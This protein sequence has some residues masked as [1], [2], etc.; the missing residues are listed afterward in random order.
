MAVDPR[1]KAGFT[2]DKTGAAPAIENKSNIKYGE[3]I[4]AGSDTLPSLEAFVGQ[5]AAKR[6]I[7]LAMS[8]AKMRGTRLDHVLLASGLAGIGKTTLARLIAY[9]MGVGL[10]ECSG[11]ITA[12]DVIRLVAGMADND[13]LFIDEL[14]TIGKGKGSAWILPLMTEGHIL[15]PTGP[16]EVANITV[17]GATTDT[18]QLSEAILSRFMVKPRI[19]HY[20]VDEATHITMQFTDRLKVDLDWEAC[21]KI[22]E[23]ANRNPRNI[24]ALVTTARDLAAVEGSVNMEEL[25]DLT[26]FTA[27]GLDENMQGYLIALSGCTNLQASVNT[28]CAILGETGNLTHIEKDLMARGFIEIMPRGRKLSA[29][30]YQRAK[31]LNG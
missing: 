1:F 13:I 30:G 9:E 14:H 28:L 5:E 7:N 19:Q 31:Q 27:D 26:G 22:A 16:V 23:A 4:F 8:S 11:K 29:A 10:V 2:A 6:Q 24:R 18:G 21:E 12:E 20:T 25:L 3:Q 15:T 17:I